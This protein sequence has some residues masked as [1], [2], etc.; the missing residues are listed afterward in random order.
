MSALMRLEVR[1]WSTVRIFRLWTVW[2]W[3]E[4]SGT[5]GVG[6]DWKSYWPGQSGGIWRGGILEQGRQGMEVGPS[7]VCVWEPSLAN[8]RGLLGRLEGKADI[9]VGDE[10]DCL[11]KIRLDEQAVKSKGTAWGHVTLLEMK[12]GIG[13]KMRRLW[14]VIPRS[15]L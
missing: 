1:P 9:S 3:M 14:I 4:I 11:D 15:F 2:P 12:R 5:G 6:K 8:G 10:G 13:W 7:L